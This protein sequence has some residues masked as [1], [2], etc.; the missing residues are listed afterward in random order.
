MNTGV[1][2]AERLHLLC[3]QEEVEEER[4]WLSALQPGG[5]ASK[6][7]AGLGGG[8]K[9]RTA[10]SGEHVHF[11]GLASRQPRR[12]CVINLALRIGTVRPEESL[13]CPR[14][15]SW[16]GRW[17][18]PLVLDPPEHPPPPEELGQERGESAQVY[19]DTDIQVGVGDI[20][21]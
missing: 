10:A 9:H 19:N 12:A 11:L 5:E 17:A 18:P 8:S 21:F 7:D 3:T 16:P 1:C 14:W 6:E 13:P 20:Y 2:G 15:L 4:Q